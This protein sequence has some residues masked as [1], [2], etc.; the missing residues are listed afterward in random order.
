MCMHLC[1]TLWFSGHNPVYVPR[2]TIILPTCV[3]L[4][5]C[6][7]QYWHLG[8]EQRYIFHLINLSLVSQRVKKDTHL[9]SSHFLNKASIQSRDRLSRQ[10]PIRTAAVSDSIWRTI[11]HMKTQRHSIRENSFQVQKLFASS[12]SSLSSTIK[13]SPALCTDRWQRL[14]HI[15]LSKP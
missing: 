10:S 6:L 1:V 4:V 5:Q 12:G 13:P 15:P 9:P 2:W 11:Q 7:R 14:K 3:I 8:A